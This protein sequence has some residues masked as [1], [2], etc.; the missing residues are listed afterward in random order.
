MQMKTKVKGSLL[1]AASR[2]A[3]VVDVGTCLLRMSASQWA[4]RLSC[5]PP[6]PMCRLCTFIEHDAHSA[7][8]PQH[9]ATRLVPVYARDFSISEWRPLVRVLRAA[10]ALCLC[11]RRTSQLV[12]FS[13]RINALVLFAAPTSSNYGGTAFN[14][15]FIINVSG[16]HSLQFFY[17]FTVA[18]LH[19]RLLIWLHE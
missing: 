1:K 15:T 12:L 8:D 6:T 18:V 3:E 17:N 11:R 19:T 9:C 7:H 5:Q 2:L 16:A 14:F 10:S 4:A 13:R